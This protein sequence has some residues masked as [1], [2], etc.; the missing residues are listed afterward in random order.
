M[1]G[2]NGGPPRVMAGSNGGPSPAMTGEGNAM[3][4]FTKLTAIAAPMP[5]ANIDTDKV[6][7]A[8]FLTTIKR[9]GLGVHLFDTLRYDNE[10][11]ERPEFVLNQ[12]PYRRAQ[13]IIAH[14]NFGCGSSREHAPWALLDFGIRCVIAPDF[15]DI[16]F[17]NSFKNGVLPVRLPRAIC[18]TLIEDARLGGNARITIDLERQVVVRPNGEEIHFDIDPFRK[19]LLLNGLDDIGQTMQ[20]APRIDTFEATR[21]QQQPW[22]PSTAA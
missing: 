4:K 17:N 22:L 7:P 2:S 16:F 15:A 14:E 8:R 9:S 1:T 6:I 21:R 13:V 10:G 12:E 19:H 3:D 5:M 11:K 18:D 20:H